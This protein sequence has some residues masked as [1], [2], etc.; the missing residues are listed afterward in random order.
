MATATKAIAALRDAGLVETRSGAGTVVRSGSALPERTTQREPELSRERVVRAA[1]ALADAEGG[2]AL[3]MRRVAT[4]LGVA[5]MSLY[6]HVPSKDELLLHMVDTVFADSPFPGH[7][8]AGWRASAEFAARLMWS[9]FRAHPW[10]AEQLSMTRPQLLPHLL[11]YTEWTVGPLAALGLPN[12]VVLSFHLTLF[13][14]VR[15]AAMSLHAESQAV[16]ETGLTADEWLDTQE[17]D[18]HALLA[19][20]DYPA[21]ARIVRQDFDYD[22]NRLFEFGLARLLDGFEV[23]LRRRARSR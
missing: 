4:D 5:T 6:R 17:G 2:P 16:Q 9:V 12:D 23:L 1:I 20:G 7:R 19:S 3:S 10:A 11:S 8:P 22:A 14:H 18:L 21:F 15:S 13:G